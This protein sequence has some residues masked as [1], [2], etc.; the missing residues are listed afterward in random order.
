MNNISLCLRHRV[1]ATD[2]ASKKLTL[3]VRNQNEE[4]VM[5]YQKL[6]VATGCAAVRFPD[7]MGGDLN[8]IH[9]IRQYDDMLRLY[10]DVKQ[11]LQRQ[12]E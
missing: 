2:F 5:T 1:V 6:I 4:Q 12:H 11:V 3:N 7:S 10:E 8:G 9:Y